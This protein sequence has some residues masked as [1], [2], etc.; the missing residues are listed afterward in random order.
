MVKGMKQMEIGMIP[1][2]WRVY[3]VLELIDLLTD[4]DAN[5]S[6]SSVAENVKSY[7]YEEYAWYVRSTDLENNSKLSDV[8]Y[9]DK[10]SYDFL[11]KTS[12]YG[13]ELLF[14]KRGDIGNVYLFEMRTE[15]ATLAPNLYLLKLNKVS[16]AKYLYQ[17]F[18]SA[19]GQRQLKSKN[20]GS[21]L[22]ALYKDD[23]KSMLVPLPPL[24]EQEAIAGALSD[25]DAWIESLEQLISKKRLIKQGAMQ[26]LL[27]PKEK[28]EVKK[29]GDMS[30]IYTGKKNNQDKIENGKYPFFVRS[31]NVERINSYSF[32]G[33]AILIPGEGNLGS[34]VHYI[35]GKF[36]FHQRVYKVSDFVGLDG[37]FLYWYFRMYFGNHAMQNTV[38]ATVDSIRLPTLQ[39]FKI[40]FP[41]FTEQTRI[42]TILSDMDAELEALEQQLHKARQIKQ[43]MM[44]ELL[45][46]RVRLV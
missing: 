7:N 32:D 42:A 5:G 38:K 3:T 13:G 9:V 30:V 27:T 29:L 1:E 45:T 34:I 19:N 46:G 33:E 35:N 4:Y 43:G 37:K 8:K 6:F 2:D 10:D 25:A 23:V 12:L 36:D 11:K 18:I 41:S 21:T 31:Q 40:Q 15:R 24:P 22:G 20:A 14:L 16:S 44:Q 26:E 17:Y 39:E 28:W